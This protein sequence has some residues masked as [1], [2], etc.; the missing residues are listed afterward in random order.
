MM[1]PMNT[2]T[3]HLTAI[4]DLTTEEVEQIL[5]RADLFKQEPP[6]NSLNGKILASCFFE[7]STRTKLS[8]E[9]AMLRL[10]GSTIGFADAGVSSQAKGESL[11]DSI[12][13]IQH[14]ADVIVLRHPLEGAAQWAAQYSSVPVINAGDGGHQHPTQTLL[15]LY[16]IRECQGGLKN[17]SI[18]LA[19]DLKFGRTV[20]SLLQALTPYK[21]RI[22][23]V[24]PP[25]LE[26]PSTYCDLMRS[27]G[28]KYS[29]HSS[30]KEVLPKTNVLYMTRIQNERLGSH[31]E[32]KRMR[33]HYT[34]HPSLLENVKESFRI[35]HPL[36]R[37]SEIPNEIDSTPYAYYFQQAHNGLFVRQALLTTLL[38]PAEAPC[39]R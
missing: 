34:L 31:P 15:D 37:T 11:Q 21:P 7:P 22:Y 16:S 20:H 33:D 30:L 25:E 12:G 28:I 13:V 36:P 26:L 39:K 2:T 17:L 14:Y 23:L 4:D 3:H 27:S 1:V 6:S 18:T 10:G 19:G 35:L 29:Y 32:I 38:E 5:D 9:S 8:F 24:S